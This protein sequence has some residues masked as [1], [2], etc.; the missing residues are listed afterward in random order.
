MRWKFHVDDPARPHENSDWPRCMR[1]GYDHASHVNPVLKCAGCLCGLCCRADA[2]ATADAVA[3]RAENEIGAGQA[4]TESHG[5][6][7]E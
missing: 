6:Q 1:C 2:G 7:N 4:G 5:N 3:V